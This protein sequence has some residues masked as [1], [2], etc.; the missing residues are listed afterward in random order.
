MYFPYFR[1][2]QEELLAI[3]EVN[4]AVYPEKVLP[5]IEPVSTINAR[6]NNIA[7]M[8]KDN[9]PFILIVNPHANTTPAGPT[10]NDILTRYVNGGLSTYSNYHL[11]FIVTTRTTIADI[12]AFMALNPNL[13]KVLIHQSEFSQPNNLIAFNPNLLYNIY[14]EGKV[15]NNYISTTSAGSQKVLIRDGFQ[16]LVRNA[17]YPNS[18]FFSDLHN[19]YQGGGYAGFGD[20]LTV[21]SFFSPGGGPANAVAIHLTSVERGDLHV[22]HFVSD[23]KAG[24]GLVPEKFGE[25]LAH[26]VNHVQGNRHIP[27]TTGLREYLQTHQ[28]GHFPG[29]A[30]NKRFSMKHHIEQVAIL[31]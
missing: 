6:I 2:K 27:H 8:C 23:N 13:N 22:Q 31:I 3:L 10:Q 5:I 7:K 28:T 16:K 9:I 26:L 18:S 4:R 17:D 19:T 14:V 11:G 21:G 15:S 24:T 29:L 12:R 30:K 20:F 25:A 1:G